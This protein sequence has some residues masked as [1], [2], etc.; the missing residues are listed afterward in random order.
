MWI[1]LHW[2]QW[3]IEGIV[4][5]DCI[6]VVVR[7]KKSLVREEIEVSGQKFCGLGFPAGNDDPHK[8]SAR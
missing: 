2:T 5:D 3:K 8:L 7:G 1:D 6:V 4:E